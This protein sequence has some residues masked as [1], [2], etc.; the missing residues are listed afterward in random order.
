MYRLKNAIKEL[1]TPGHGM[2]DRSKSLG[3]CQ[4]ANEVSNR[5]SGGM[6]RRAHAGIILVASE[7]C[8]S[9]AQFLE[10]N[11]LGVSGGLLR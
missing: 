2:G 5:E 9:T 3:E 1:R 11:I 10:V 6:S 8:E 4:E 7:R